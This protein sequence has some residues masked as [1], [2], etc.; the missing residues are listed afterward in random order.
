MRGFQDS[1]DFALQ[2]AGTCMHRSFEFGFTIEDILD[3]DFVVDKKVK[4]LII[5]D[6]AVGAMKSLR[7][8]VIGFADA[9]GHLKPDL[10]T[11][12]GGR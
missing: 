6:T 12:L 2:L 8:A 1:S 7:L 9:Y 3:S 5:S 4:K 10:V 11:P